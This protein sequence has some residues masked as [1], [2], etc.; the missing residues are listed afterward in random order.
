MIRGPGV[1]S[2]KRE[3]LV[4]APTNRR[5]EAGVQ[6]TIPR[7]FLAIIN[8]SPLNPSLN[9]TGEPQVRLVSKT[10]DS[11]RWLARGIAAVSKN[12]SR[13]TLILICVSTLLRVAFGA[14]LGLGIDE[15]YMVA[16]ARVPQLSYFDHPPLAWWLVKF[17][18]QIFGNDQ[19]LAV[20]LP[21]ILL[22]SLSTWLL[23]R[24]TAML[25]GA[26]AGFYAALL[27]NLSPVFALA[28]GS[29]VLPDGPLDCAL[30][31]TAI[32]FVH[33][34]REDR[35]AHYWWLGLGLCAGLA[36]LSKYL[37]VLVL[38][39]IPF[40]LLSDRRLRVWFQRP[41]PYFAVAI[42]VVLST[43]M[44]QWN[45]THGWT[46]LLFQGSRAGG[47]RFQPWGPIV[48]IAGEVLFLLPW[49]GLPLLAHFGNGVWRGPRDT[50][51]WLLCSL[52]AGP[53]L[54]FALISVWSHAR[55]L[56]HWAAPGYLFLL[57]LL[58]RDVAARLDAGERWIRRAVV[59][60][61][62]LVCGAAAIMATEV[63]W[64]W[65]PDIGEHFRSGRDPALQ[66]VNWSSVAAAIKQRHDLDRPGVIVAGTNWR[67]TGKLDYA[68]DGQV[69]VTCLCDDAREFGILRP[70][71]NYAG[72]DVVIVTAMASHEEVTR[73]YYEFFEQLTPAGPV[74]I[75]HAGVPSATLYLYIGHRLRLPK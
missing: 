32:C 31:G 4:P 19:P 71:T 60:T 35:Y 23:Y 45:A 33:V 20:R 24:L 67:D 34:V 15:S 25:F 63:K 55:M 48:T 47:M 27:L 46:S 73:R 11:H 1:L 30:L 18:T 16:T 61:A 5:C 57:P 56:Y 29:W 62:I 68:L 3:E 53:I 39:G 59:A 2:R 44:L 37:A 65:L 75:E 49:I 66:A 54:S 74:V 52:A 41:Q 40:V 36:M 17:A 72:A 43:P 50:R 22:F 14:M 51:S 7:P 28:V 8:E 64:N 42:A 58:G 12:P 9:L 70:L 13:A 26:A 69:P 10:A 21:F 6:T 38:M